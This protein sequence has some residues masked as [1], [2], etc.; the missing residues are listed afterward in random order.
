MTDKQTKAYDKVMSL[1]N[2]TNTTLTATFKRYNDLEDL[3]FFHTPK[4]KNSAKSNIFDPMAYEQVEHSVSHIF[5]NEPK[6]QFIP[7]GIDDFEGM[8]LD[9]VLSVMNELIKQQWNKQDADMFR[10]VATTLRRANLYGV[11]WG[12][13]HWRYERVFD[14]ATK[15]FTT[16][17]DDWCYYPLSNYDVWP[18]MDAQTFKEMEFFI[19]DEYLTI[20]DLEAQN[21]VK[22]KPRYVNLDELKANIGESPASSVI[23]NPYRNNLM[24]RRKVNTTT[25]MEGKIKVRRCYYKDRWITI[26]PDYEVLIED[27]P[28][29][30]GNGKLPAR[31]LLDQDIPGM[32]LGLGEI[33]PVRTLMMAMN[34]FIN[35]RMDNI[36][37]NMERP[38]QVK[39][40]AVEFMKSYVWGRNRIWPVNQMD[41]VKLL[42]VQDVTG[43]TFISTLNWLQDV[44]RTRSGRSDILTSNR[45]NKTA[46]E[47]DAVA[48]EQNARLKYKVHNFDQ[49]IKDI[50]VGGMELNQMFI[51]TSRFLRIIG[52]DDINSLRQKFA[53]DPERLKVINDSLAFLKVSKEDILGQFDYLVETGSTLMSNTT[54]DIQNLSQALQLGTNYEQALMSNGK[55]FDPSPIIKQMFT[56][57]GI[58]DEV[59]KDAQIL[60][61]QNGTIPTQIAG[62]SQT[63][64][65]PAPGGF[66]Q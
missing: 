60:P 38:I 54:R 3:Y 40:S 66:A 52:T 57:L 36:K 34:Q 64:G 7:V 14:E 32:V 4:V 43:P 33:D 31:C 18:D 15:K 1:W 8:N 44:I 39:K 47:I 21:S 51:K 61:T 23:D 26:C 27:N 19:H 46:T 29:P 53:N 22:G 55:T 58:K 16:V 42:E 25:Q 28:N 30:Y 13:Q 37:M 2:R 56:K 17:W 10:K 41:D 9:V 20:D 59:I 6:G 45:G 5:S 12:V 24:I 62:V 49:F 65:I 63:G 11:G 48:E 35:M 50:M